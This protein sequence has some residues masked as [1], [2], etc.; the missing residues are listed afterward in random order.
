MTQKLLGKV[1]SGKYFGSVST[2]DSEVTT[3]YKISLAGAS[4]SSDSSTQSR[5]SAKIYLDTLIS[6]PDVSKF[7]VIGGQVLAGDTSYDILFGKARIT[8]G[9]AQQTMTLVAQIMDDDANVTT[10]KLTLNLDSSLQDIDQGLVD[11]EVLSTKS[12]IGDS[13]TLEGSG[14]ILLL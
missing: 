4:T 11:V 14:Q 2:Q 1:Q 10:L 3:S 5:M 6:G 8:G 9:Q 7:S 12:T 13:W